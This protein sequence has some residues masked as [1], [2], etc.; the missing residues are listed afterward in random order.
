MQAAGRHKLPDF[1]CAC[2]REAMLA[3]LQSG[4]TLVVDRYSYSGV[5]F[6]SAKQSPGLDLTWCKVL[7][8]INHAAVLK[9]ISFALGSNHS[10]LKVALYI[11]QAQTSIVSQLWLSTLLLALLGIATSGPCLLQGPE[12]GLPAPDLVLYLRLPQLEIA[13]QRGGY[14]NERCFAAAS[15]RDSFRQLCPQ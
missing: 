15:T 3:A 10:G 14:G 7:A 5:V 2:G 11:S 6:T 12:T 13:A 9:C 4:T 8:Q 1:W